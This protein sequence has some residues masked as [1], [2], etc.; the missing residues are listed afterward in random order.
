MFVCFFVG[1]CV[2]IFV[3][4]C[5]GAFVQSCIS[6]HMIFYFT[7]NRDGVKNRTL[8]LLLLF[9]LFMLLL[10]L[11]LLL[12]LHWTATT[13]LYKQIIV[14]TSEH[15]HSHILTFFHTYTYTNNLTEPY[16]N[17]FNKRNRIRKI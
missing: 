17:V 15:A 3:C 2:R 12:F 16:N 5:V 9:L 13:M 1:M 7:H 10:L 8:L 6:L 4:V 11:L 14:H